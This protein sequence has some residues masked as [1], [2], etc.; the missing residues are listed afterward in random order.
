MKSIFTKFQEKKILFAKNELNRLIKEKKKTKKTIYELKQSLKYV[1]KINSFYSDSLKLE[2]TGDLTRLY[3][4]LKLIE[5]EI[6][7]Y[8]LYINFIKN[9]NKIC[10][11][12][13]KIDKELKAKIVNNPE[14]LDDIFD[15]IV[16][17]TTY[18]VLK[19][20]SIVISNSRSSYKYYY[21]TIEKL[22]S[23]TASYIKEDNILKI[24]SNLNE[25]TDYINNNFKDSFSKKRLKS[26]KELKRFKKQYKKLNEDSYDL[27]NLIDF[28][29]IKKKILS[30]TK[31]IKE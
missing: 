21:E 28:D 30:A 20:K 23:Y 22:N 25:A 14:K 9:G 27:N 29:M 11:N 8:D 5:D 3:N 24:F 19:N 12:V 10:L 15:F 1:P 17:M 7:L 31:D 6:L 18:I 26:L 2:I 16:P 4:K 13:K